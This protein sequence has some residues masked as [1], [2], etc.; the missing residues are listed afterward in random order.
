MHG[1]NAIRP[2]S[3]IHQKKKYNRA[4][5][6]TL[7]EYSRIHKSVLQPKGLISDYRAVNKKRGVLMCFK[8]LLV[9]KQQRN[10]KIRQFSAKK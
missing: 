6:A 10:F 4:N 5:H 7:T 3:L 9:A 2:N 1:E 8:L